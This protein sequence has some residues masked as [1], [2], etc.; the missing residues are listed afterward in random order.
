[1]TV[2][3]HYGPTSNI[4]GPEQALGITTMAIPFRA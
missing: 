1:M 3:N 2:T 4:Y